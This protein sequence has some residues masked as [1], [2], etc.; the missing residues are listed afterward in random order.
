MQTELTGAR[1]ASDPRAIPLP[2]YVAEVMQVL[3]AGDHPGG[4]VLVA[5]DHG[6]RT[7]ER[8]GRYDAVFAQMNPA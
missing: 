8:E 6:R 4:E 1:Q 2:A 5:A 3:E 7:A